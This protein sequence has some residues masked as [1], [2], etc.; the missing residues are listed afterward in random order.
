MRAP[1]AA[2]RAGIMLRTEAS[3]LEGEI[4][5]TGNYVVVLHEE[6]TTALYGHITHNGMMMSLGDVVQAGTPLGLSGNTGNTGT[7]PHLHMQSCDPA[8][9][10]RPAARRCR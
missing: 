5:E 1:V 6:G 2:A 8:R 9:E 7:S 4:S 3:H 10:A